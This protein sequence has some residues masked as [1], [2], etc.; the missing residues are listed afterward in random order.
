MFNSDFSSNN[1]YYVLGGGQSQVTDILSLEIKNMGGK[2]FLRTN[3][4]KPSSGAP[5]II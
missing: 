1:Q 5:Q 3:C 4:S 2:M